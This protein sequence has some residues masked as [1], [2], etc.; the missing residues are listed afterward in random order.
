MRRWRDHFYESGCM[1]S[2]ETQQ[3]EFCCYEVVYEHDDDFEPDDNTD[4]DDGVN[5][6]DNTDPDDG[7]DPDDNTDPDDGTNPDDGSEPDY[8]TQAY[9]RVQNSWGLGWG[10]DGFIKFAIEGGSGA[11]GMNQWVDAVQIA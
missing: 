9:W 10:D 8:T 11:C 2:D 4:P 1:H 3:G 6:D 5:P 7:V